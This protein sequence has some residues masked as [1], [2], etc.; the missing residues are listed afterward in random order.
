[1]FRHESEDSPS[2]FLLWFSLAPLSCHN[3]STIN[4]QIKPESFQ[5]FSFFFALTVNGS[6]SSAFN[7]FSAAS[8]SSSF[9]FHSRP[10][11]LKVDKFTQ[12]SRIKKKVFKA[13]ELRNGN[14]ARMGMGGERE[15][16][17]QFEH[18]L[19]RCSEVFEKWRRRGRQEQTKL[20]PRTIVAINRD[21]KKFSTLSTS[22]S[23]LS[24]YSKSQTNSMRFPQSIRRDSLE[25]RFW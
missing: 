14:D 18:Y 21:R 5:Y 17:K 15:K 7:F 6:L 19:W 9:C 25:G 1:M 4:S 12:R 13:H 22:K 10:K 11:Y 8:S 2:V 20:S 24:R 16:E 3:K 23:R